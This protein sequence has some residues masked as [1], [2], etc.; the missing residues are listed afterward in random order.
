MPKSWSQVI[1]VSFDHFAPADFNVWLRSCH[2]YHKHNYALLRSYN[3][4]ISVVTV[5]FLD[6]KSFS[7]LQDELAVGDLATSSTPSGQHYVIEEA[8]VAGAGKDKD[9]LQH[10]QL[11]ADDPPSQIGK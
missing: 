1:L 8:L 7:S 4:R 9:P 10:I 2:H 5:L 11:T 3:W 6:V